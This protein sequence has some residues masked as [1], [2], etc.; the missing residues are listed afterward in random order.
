[1]YAGL[2]AKGLNL[3]AINNGDKAEVINKY[4]A[5]GGF[6]FPIVLG[7]RGQNSVF[8]QYGVQAYPTNYLLD[9]EG[10]VV[11]RSVGFDEAG[12]RAALERLALK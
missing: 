2:K 8:S 10:N 1:M 9:G 6:T 12:L 11:F 4:V 3:I 5:E 7:E